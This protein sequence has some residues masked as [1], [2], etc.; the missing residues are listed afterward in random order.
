MQVKEDYKVRRSARAKRARIVVSAEKVEI[1]V[2]LRMPEKYI[3]QFVQDKQAWVESAKNKVQQYVESIESFAPA[4]YQQGAM[5]PFQGEQSVL[6]VKF[7]SR[8]QVKIDFVDCF[9]ADVPERWQEIL[10]GV[11]LNVRIRQ[12]LIEWLG[13]M[14]A[15]QATKYMD[16][17][18]LLYQ[19]EPRSVTLKV[20]KSRWGSCGIHDDIYLNWLLILAPGAVFEYVVV[21]EL[22]HIQQRNHSA[23]F[24]ALVAQHCPDYQQHRAWLKRHGASLMLG[25]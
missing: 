14:A 25:L 13:K 17:Y 11:E 1:V 7:S 22:C 24:W 10:T 5:I 4:S 23:A 16:K 6:H 2:P 19:L 3:Q 20:Q 8:H 12:A 15:C 21:H 9:V 18:T